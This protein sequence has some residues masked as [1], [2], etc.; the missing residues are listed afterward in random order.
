MTRHPKKKEPEKKSPSTDPNVKDVPETPPNQAQGINLNKP[1]DILFWVRVGLGV[2][3]GAIAAEM[4]NPLDVE[5]R[6]YL[7]FGIMII[8]FLISIAIAKAM[9]IP[10]PSS[11]KKK[12]VTTGIGSYFFMFIFSWILV[13]TLI[14]AE[15]SIPGIR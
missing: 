2:L 6:P 1:L 4:G 12:L 8:L 10:L 9:R 7:G 3:A 5:T 14:H 15:I 11:D 13:N